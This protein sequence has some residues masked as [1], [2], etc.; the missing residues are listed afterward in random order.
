MNKVNFLNKDNFPLYSEGL[1]KL[2]NAIFQTANLALL[3]GQ[4]YILSG[5]DES[6][7]NNV[8]MIADGLVVINGETL[9]LVGAAK[10]SKIAIREIRTPLSAFGVEYPESY[11]TRYVEFSGTGEY[12]WSDFEKIPTNQEL[13]TQIKNI[14]GDPAGTI[15]EWAGFIA[16]IPKD[17]MFCDGRELSVIEYAE[18]YE[19]IGT[20]YGGDGVNSF[21][22][23][24]RRGRVSVG[25]S[26]D[27]D[28]NSQGNTGGEEKHKLTTDEL[29]KHNHTDHS[30]TS[31]N[32]LSARAADVD[33]TNTPSGVDAEVPDAEYRV[34]G[35]TSPQWAEAT[36]KA[37]GDDEPH[38]NRQPYI[39][40]A[41][42]IKV[43]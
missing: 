35:M 32:K 10:K 38:E 40:Q 6:V 22:I 20:L 34:A 13:Y 27:G 29:P 12:N 9:E 42:I 26:G 1:A 28:Y 16:R 36:I 19:N 5:C 39:V 11:I 8:E 17:Y 18:L 23:P 14:T 21:R 25:Y 24:D 43:R 37:V 41:H 15:K 3:G 33:A 30:S 31:F 7:I 2:Q 4:T